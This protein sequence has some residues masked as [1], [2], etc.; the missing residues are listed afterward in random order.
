[1]LDGSVIGIANRI[2]R[3]VFV[4]RGNESLEYKSIKR[5]EMLD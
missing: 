5:R 3:F 2:H 4:K 1:M